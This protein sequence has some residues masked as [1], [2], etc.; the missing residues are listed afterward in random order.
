MGLLSPQTQHPSELTRGQPIER[1]HQV[2]QSMLDTDRMIDT[3]Q[4]K[5]ASVRKALNR[6]D[7]YATMACI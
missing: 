2:L 5:P 6:Q 4:Q 3:P 7:A 1:S